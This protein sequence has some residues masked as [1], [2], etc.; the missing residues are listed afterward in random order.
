MG[1][2]RVP[3]V[4][5]AIAFYICAR[6][7][8][9]FSTHGT[10]ALKTVAAVGHTAESAVVGAAATTGWFQSGVGHIVVNEIFHLADPLLFVADA[11]QA[12]GG[13]V[14]SHPLVYLSVGVV[15]TGD[16]SRCDVVLCG[17]SSSWYPSILL[18]HHVLVQPVAGS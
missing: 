17:T 18:I 3:S 8:Q 7:Q 14:L 13:S 6:E 4:S 2:H 9:R 11:V 10:G 16:R 1:T 5:Q 12:C 15:D